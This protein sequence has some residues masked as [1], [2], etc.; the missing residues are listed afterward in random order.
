[1]WYVINIRP[2][3]V[4]EPSLLNGRKCRAYHRPIIWSPSPAYGDV[5]I[6]VKLLEWDVKHHS[7]KQ[8]KTMI[9]ASV[10]HFYQEHFFNFAQILDIQA[11]IF[12]KEMRGIRQGLTRQPPWSHLNSPKSIYWMVY[13]HNSEKNKSKLYVKLL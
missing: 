6:W 10:N 1:M 3:H 12:P 5:S 9:T 7:N 11:C 2:R 4:K 13:C 8:N